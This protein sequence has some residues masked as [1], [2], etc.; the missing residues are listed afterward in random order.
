MYLGKLFMSFNLVILK[1]TVIIISAIN[2]D[3]VMC[4]TDPT[5]AAACSFCYHTTI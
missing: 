3:F 2:V 4:V 5:V 1:F